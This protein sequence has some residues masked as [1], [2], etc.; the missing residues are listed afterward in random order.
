MVEWTSRALYAVAVELALGA[1]WS[2]AT[3]L[4]ASVGHTAAIG[5]AGLLGW[6]RAAAL[7]SMALPASMKS[8]DV[9]KQAMALLDEYS[10]RRLGLGIATIIITLLALG[11]YLKIRRT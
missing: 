10:F 1:G 5:Q 3:S 4:R 2:S 7:G 8:T 9:H 6:R 11:L